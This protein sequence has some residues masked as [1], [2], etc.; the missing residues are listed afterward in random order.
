MDSKVMSAR[1]I[2]VCKGKELETQPAVCEEFIRIV[3]EI[4]GQDG[5]RSWR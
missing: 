2:S 1:A 5:I 3:T 4:E